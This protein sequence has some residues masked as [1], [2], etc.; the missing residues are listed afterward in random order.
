MNQPFIEIVNF[1][2][3]E[4]HDYDP[5][6]LLEPLA[7]AAPHELVNQLLVEIVELLD[8]DFDFDNVDQVDLQQVLNEPHNQNHVPQPLAPEPENAQQHPGA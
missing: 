1:P 7:Q 5:N 2:L 8:V 6:N 3:Q 4:L